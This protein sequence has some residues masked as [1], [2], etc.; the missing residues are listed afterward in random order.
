MNSKNN[1]RF[2]QTERVIRTVFIDLLKEKKRIAENNHHG[3]LP[4][5]RN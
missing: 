1:Q 3:N 2:Q 5:G 4:F